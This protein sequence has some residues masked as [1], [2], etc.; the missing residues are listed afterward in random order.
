M[1]KSISSE[2]G[3]KTIFATQFAVDNLKMADL[4]DNI[5]PP[6]INFLDQDLRAISKWAHDELFETVKF[7]YRGEDEL[8]STL[9]KFGNVY[10]LFVSGCRDNLPGVKASVSQGDAYKLVYVNNVWEHAKKKK[11]VH[12]AL[13][14]R[15]STI[16]TAMQIKFEGKQYMK[17][18]DVTT[19]SNTSFCSKNCVIFVQRTNLSFQLW[20]PWK[21]GWI[22]R[23]PTSYFMI[24]FYEPQSVTER[25]NEI[26]DYGNKNG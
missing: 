25:G 6:R 14:I 15:R 8:K 26:S 13:S 10:K 22:T 18:E 11:V 24:T 5:A 7:L 2:F 3:T 20:K 12:A 19:L 9:P 23:T 21:R 16:Y 4:D 1:L 17:A